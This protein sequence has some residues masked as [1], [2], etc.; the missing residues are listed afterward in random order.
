[1]FYVGISCSKMDIGTA[2]TFRYF[3]FHCFVATDMSPLYT[4]S[5]A[6]LNPGTDETFPIQQPGNYRT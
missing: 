1:M 2:E 5:R 4:R 3:C 6:P